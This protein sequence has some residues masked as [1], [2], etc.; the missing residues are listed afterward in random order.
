MRK[1][2]LFLTCLT[3]AALTAGSAVCR[4][5]PVFADADSFHDNGGSTSSYY[6]VTTDGGSWDGTYY[7]HPD[8]LRVHNA[9]FCDGTYTYYLQN[10]GT[11]MKDRLTYH[12]DG[13]HVI[14]F[15]ADGH[16]VFS[17]FAHISKSIA[18]DDVDDMCFFNV[19]GYMYVDTLTYDKTGTKLYYVN[20]YGV[21]ERKGWFSF[22]GHEFDA[23]LGFSGK[24]GGRGYANFDCSLMTNAD[25]YDENGNLVRILGDGHVY[26]SQTGAGGNGGTTDSDNTGE[27]VHN[28]TVTVTTE[29]VE[30]FYLETKGTREVR[31]YTCTVCG[32]TYTEY[33]NPLPV[34]GPGY[35][36]DIKDETNEPDADLGGLTAEEYLGENSIT[37]TGSDSKLYYME[38][39]MGH[40]DGYLYVVYNQDWCAG[41]YVKSQGPWT[42]PQQLDKVYG[43]GT[44]KTMEMWSVSPEGYGYWGSACSYYSRYGGDHMIDLGWYDEGQVFYCIQRNENNRDLWNVE[45]STPEEV[46]KYYQQPEY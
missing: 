40:I 8:G 46:S 9:F 35:D 18:G 13:E 23:G 7:T 30:H 29:E 11:P 43:D 5:V 12:P 38:K 42:G 22:S 3:A 15:D 21:L 14:Y 44:Q 26:G 33:G 34:D 25:T 16:E 24:S 2:K 37:V 28:Y 31:T 19:Y 17:D 45:R 32:D 4:T 20:P 39:Y 36:S 27:H 41:F 1:N 10:D 6:N